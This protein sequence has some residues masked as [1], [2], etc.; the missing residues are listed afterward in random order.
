VEQRK[1]DVALDVG[2]RHVDVIADFS[3]PIDSP[4]A[5]PILHLVLYLAP[6]FDQHLPQVCTSRRGVHVPLQP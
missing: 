2:I 1:L 6:T 4:S 3:A 5:D